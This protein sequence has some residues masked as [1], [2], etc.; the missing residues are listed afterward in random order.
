MSM[1][2]ER[3]GGEWRERRRNERAEEELEDKRDRRG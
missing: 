2:R 3:G 1:W